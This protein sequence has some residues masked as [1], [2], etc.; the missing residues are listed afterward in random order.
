MLSRRDALTMTG[1]ALAMPALAGAALAQSAQAAGLL[2]P[3]PLRDIW[4]GPADAKA[5]IIEYAAVTCPH[6]AAFHRDT[7]PA[8]KQRWVETGKVR[9]VLRA[10]ALNPLDTAGFMLARADDA[11]RYYPITDLLF[12]QQAHWAFVQKP[13]DALAQMMRQAGFSKETFEAALRDQTL[14]AAFNAS[15]QRAET[16]FQVHSTPTLFINGKRHEGEVS[17]AALESILTPLTAP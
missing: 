4:L 14:Y 5:T 16:V 12:D 2:D 6:C 15:Q 17:I 9:F 10:F 7:W 8:L 11:A 13:L 1:A 3:G